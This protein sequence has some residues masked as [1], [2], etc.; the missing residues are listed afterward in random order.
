MWAI[1]LLIGVV[2]L[3]HLNGFLRGAWKP[4]IDAFLSVCWIVLLVIIFIQLSW[5]IGLAW[6]A[7]SYLLGFV[8]R[9]LAAVAASM[10]LRR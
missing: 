3:I 10:I 6:V 9:P 8:L 1:A 5:K 2:F 4:Q 7:G